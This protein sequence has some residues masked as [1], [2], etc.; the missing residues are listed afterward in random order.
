MRAGV[1]VEVTD[2]VVVVPVVELVVVVCLVVVRTF[3]CVEM[4]LFLLQSPRVILISSTAMSD[5]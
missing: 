1:A 4:T 3:D 2:S 5:W